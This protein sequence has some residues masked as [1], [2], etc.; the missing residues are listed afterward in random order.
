MK[1]LLT[2]EQ[3]SQYL[4]EA[5]NPETPP[6]RLKQIA[7][8]GNKKIRKAVAA[9]PNTPLKVLKDLSF[10]FPKSF[11]QNPILPLWILEDANFLENW[12]DHEYIKLMEKLM[13]YEGEIADEYLDVYHFIR[14]RRTFS[15]TASPK[16]VNTE[17]LSRIMGLEH[18]DL[19]HSKITDFA[20]IGKLT[21]LKHLH[22]CH[23]V[24]DDI[25]PI[26]GL[27]QLRVLYLHE[28]KGFKSISVVENFTKLEKLNLGNSDVNDLSPLYKLTKIKELD[29]DFLPI[30]D[31]SPLTHLS[32]L[33]RLD[34]RGFITD[35]LSILDD[36][37]LKKI[38]LAAELDTQ[39]IDAFKAQHPKCQ[40]ILIKEGDRHTNV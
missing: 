2:E 33:H 8:E 21:Q 6:K 7:K 28:L 5:Q 4:A 36:K 22:V 16:P 12:W 1:N 11:L 39:V 3:V 24:V 40:V 32:H 14:T 30:T 25:A 20:H 18:L 13:V 10:K 37:P 31:I 19:C 23:N 34:L 15:Y 38:G 27:T 29:L 35:D 17:A 26:A 9:N